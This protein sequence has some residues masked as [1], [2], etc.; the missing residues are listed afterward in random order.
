MRLL[1]CDTHASMMLYRPADINGERIPPSGLERYRETH[2]FRYPCCLCAD[3]RGTG[4]YTEAAVY[5]WWDG[6]AAK[7]GWTTRCTSNTCGYQG[8]HSLNSIRES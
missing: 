3:E 8:R 7:A 2:E 5:S 4:A 1:N 6:G